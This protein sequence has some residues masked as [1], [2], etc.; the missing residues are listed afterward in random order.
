MLK[1][2]YI[3]LFR[4]KVCNFITV[5]HAMYDEHFRMDIT[6]TIFALY[7]QLLAIFWFVFP[8]SQLLNLLLETVLVGVDCLSEICSEA[9]VQSKRS[10]DDGCEWTS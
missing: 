7:M 3:L 4:K 10:T 9:S 6:L 5:Q 1:H 8:I 2:L